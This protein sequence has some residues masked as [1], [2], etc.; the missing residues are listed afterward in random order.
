MQTAATF[1]GSNIPDFVGHPP[2]ILH[3]AVLSFAPLRRGLHWK[4]PL[5][6]GAAMTNLLDDIH[7]NWRL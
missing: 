7:G 1:G 2:R 3:L 4:R 5:G 6:C